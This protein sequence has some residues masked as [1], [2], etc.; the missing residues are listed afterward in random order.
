MVASEHTGWVQYVTGGDL[1]VAVDGRPVRNYDG[2]MKILGDYEPGDV[3]RVKLYRDHQFLTVK[4]EVEAY[5]YT[6]PST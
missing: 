4:S 6:P 2:F 5:P 1:I 3:V